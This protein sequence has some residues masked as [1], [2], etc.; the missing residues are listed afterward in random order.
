MLLVVVSLLIFF[1]CCAPFVV[2]PRLRLFL[3]RPA[4]VAFGLEPLL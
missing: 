2:A 3:G 4:V 1:L